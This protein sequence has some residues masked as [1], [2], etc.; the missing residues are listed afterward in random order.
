MP[1]HQKR[2]RQIKRK[3]TSGQ[4]TPHRSHGTPS[5]KT[6]L[7][8]NTPT[9]CDNPRPPFRFRDGSQFG[10]IQTALISGLVSVLLII[11]AMV[12]FT[13][14]VRGVDLA[15]K[16]IVHLLPIVSMVFGYA[17]GRSNG[18]R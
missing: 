12:L 4:S 8:V 18:N 10:R 16:V 5:K 17:F 3:R 14:K 15:D 11:I 9:D 7:H 2:N 13:D 1:D 6:P